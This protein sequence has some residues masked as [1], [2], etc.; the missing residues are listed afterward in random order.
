[1][2]GLPL[3]LHVLYRFDT[4]GLENGVVNLINRLRGYRHAVLALD[5]CAPA[6]CQRVQRDDVEFI[7]LHKPPGQTLKMAPRFVAELRR[8]QPAL[9]HTRNLAA[10]EMQLSAWWH[11]VPARVHGEHGWDMSDLGGVSTKA[12]WTRRFYRR[13]V[14]RQVA[15]SGDLERYLVRKVGVPGAQVQRICNGVDVDRFAAFG[16]RQPLEGSPFNDPGLFVVGTVGRMQTVK[17]QT[18]LVDAFVLALQQAPHLRENLRL[19]LVGDGPLR[20]NCEQ[21]LVSAGVRD[22]AWLPG[23]RRDVPALMAHFSAFALPSLAEGISNTILEAMACG[24][25]VLATRVGGND[26]LV[27]E[28][29]TG[30]LVP[31]GEPELMAASLRDWA[32]KPD[33]VEAMG[34]EARLR[35]EQRFSLEA[36][37]GAYDELYRGLL[38]ANTSA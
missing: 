21:R 28:G 2:A 34:Y 1:M 23:E 11:G 33:R 35:V 17:A 10:L 7:S 4:G 9:V 16:K 20:L 29:V 31:A 6:F 18:Q 15:L 14:H 30:E 22:L 5:H 27:V 32:R 24:R 3:V 13:F 8:I 25:A 12:R 26:E 36:M 38:A 37:V 19:V